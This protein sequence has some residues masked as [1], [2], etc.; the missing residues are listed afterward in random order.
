MISATEM[1]VLDRNAQHFGVPILELMESAGKAVAEVARRD[2]G[3]SGKRVLVVCGTGNNGGDGLVAARHLSRDAK[4][5]ILLA[6]PPDQFATEEARVNFRRLGN[7]P[8]SEGLVASEEAMRDVDLIIDA[9]LGIGVEG[10]LREPYATLIQEMNRSG[11][12]ILSVDVPSGIG[13]DV[14]VKPAATVALHAIKE[15][16]TEANAGTLRV[17]DI[18]IPPRI[19]HSIGPG[20]FVLY[21]LPRAES[22]KGQNGN[23]LIVSGGPFTGAPALVA[24]GAQGVGADLVHIATPLVA[25]QVVASFSPSF[26]VHA[27]GGTHL[28]HADVEHVLQLGS[29]ADVLAIGPGLGDAKDTLESVREILTKTEIPFVVDADAIKAVAE[30]PSCLQGKRG[31]VTPHSR[32]FLRLTGTALPDALERRADAVREA[33]K[34]LGVTV[35]LKGHVDIVSDGQR[36]KYNYTG[37]PGMTVGG[38]GDVLCGVVAGLVSKGTAPFD[39]ARLGAFVNGAAGDLAF[40]V[41]SYGLTAMDVAENVGRV[42]AEYLR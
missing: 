5:E 20:E 22:H 38:T 11:K 2:F 39:A 9:L 29:K 32:E 13:T 8:V 42:L 37:N 14:A 36:T 17:A 18:G 40:K 3:A 24:F 26:I 35:L 21:P 15:G 33:A 10:A 23:V 28:L 27:L 6:R 4:V 34:T 25:S 30:D 41:K 7:V 31:V 19:A 16:C 12:P 1:R